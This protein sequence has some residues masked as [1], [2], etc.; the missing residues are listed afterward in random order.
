M[1]VMVVWGLGFVLLIIWDIFP[2]SEASHVWLHCAVELVTDML[3]A[4][5]LLQKQY[6]MLA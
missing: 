1:W 6:L 4:C 5:L 2:L 3:S